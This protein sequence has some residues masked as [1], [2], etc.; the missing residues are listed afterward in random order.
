[1]AFRSN[2][3]RELHTLGGRT[4]QKPAMKFTVERFQQGGHSVAT[5]LGTQPA[6]EIGENVLRW[7]TQLWPQVDSRRDRERR[8]PG[9]CS[10]ADLISDHETCQALL[11]IGK[12]SQADLVQRKRMDRVADPLT[13]GAKR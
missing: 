13:A 3:L 2:Q 1:M 10:G 7:L 5:Q 11:V 9:Q 8:C 4:E 6:A 12:R